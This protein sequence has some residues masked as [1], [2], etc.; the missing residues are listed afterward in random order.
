MAMALKDLVPELLKLDRADKLH[1]IELLAP[2]LA[3]ETTRPFPKAEYEFWSPHDSAEAARQLTKLLE[4]DKKLIS[5]NFHACI[6]QV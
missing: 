3:K 2:E 1:A 6:G 4:E 5:E